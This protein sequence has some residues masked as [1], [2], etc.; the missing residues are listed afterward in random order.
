MALFNDVCYKLWDKQKQGKLDVWIGEL[1]RYSLDALA[2]LLAYDALN[3]ELV[4]I[5]PHVCRQNNGRHQVGGVK[6]CTTA[7]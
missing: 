4:P 6:R 7:S 3:D 1:E 2:S 5:V